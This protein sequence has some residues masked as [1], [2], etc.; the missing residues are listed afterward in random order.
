MSPLLQ[1]LIDALKCLPGVGPK[2]AQRMAF[3]LLERDPDNPKARDLATEAR[4]RLALEHFDHKR[5]LEGREVLEKVQDDHEASAALKATI[6]ERLVEQAQIHY[7]NGVKHYINEDLQSAITEWEVALAC[8]PDHHKAR[9]N[10]QNARR[11]MQKIE[12]MP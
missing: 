3:H 8:D 11:I 1:Q 12:T 10:I 6:R 7:R 4:Y 9:E 2:S 5:Y